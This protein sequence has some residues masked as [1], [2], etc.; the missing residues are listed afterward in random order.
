MSNLSSVE[1]RDLEEFLGM[2]DGY[3][4]DFK[5]PWFQ[6]FVKEN[7][8]I[9][10]YEEKYEV[11]GGSKAKRL[12]AFWHQEP[13][14]TVGKL[15]FALLEYK[16][17]NYSKFSP[18]EQVLFDKCSKISQRLIQNGQNNQ[19]EIAVKADL[20]NGD[21][22]TKQFPL[23]LPF[24][25]YKPDVA[26]IP[27]GGVQHASF[28]VKS[29]MGI[30]KEKVYPNLSF[31]HLFEMLQNI[32]IS[33]VPPDMETLKENLV[34]MNQ[35]DYEKGFF[36]S[37]V[38]K[39]GMKEN[40]PVLIPQAWIQWH[41]EMKKNLRSQGSSYADDPYRV[42]FVAFWKDQR[43]VILVDGIEHYA[44]KQNNRWDANEEKYSKRLKEDRK[45]RKEGWQVF[46]VSNW[47]IRNGLIDEILVDL[48]EFLD[49]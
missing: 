13:N 41:S 38:N 34:A 31:P 29:G 9:D 10:I 23:G 32:D 37:Y 20:N 47:E 19:D 24:G 28:V 43:F 30:L 16:R 8:G 12:R 48:K 18:S 27:K 14:N 7:T 33:G 22:F 5:N 3:V 40:V 15:I 42:D 4:L 35:S 6:D 44:N 25:P 1:R 26:V 39:Y 49:F 45:L 2:K 17:S 36:I 21:L 11:N 46:R